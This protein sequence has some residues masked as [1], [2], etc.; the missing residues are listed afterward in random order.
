M[1]V[2]FAACTSRARHVLCVAAT[3]SVFTT[4]GS[5]D[6]AWAGSRPATPWCAHISG[7]DWVM[8]C[9][10]YTWQQ[11]RATVHGLG[12]FCSPNPR[13]VAV[14]DDRVERKQRRR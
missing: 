11:C 9:S 14:V 2:D 12:G 3:L 5:V 4:A 8:D 1:A 13:Y 7:A 10:F 6:A